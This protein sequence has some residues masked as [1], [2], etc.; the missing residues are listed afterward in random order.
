[1]V[2]VDKPVCYDSV[3]ACLC[4]DCQ[5]YD[6]VMSL[7][8][9][10]SSYW[11]SPLFRESSSVAESTSGLAVIDAVCAVGKRMRLHQSV[12]DPPVP[13]RRSPIFR[14]YLSRPDVAFADLSAPCFM[15][16]CDPVLPASCESDAVLSSCPATSAAASPV[17]ASPVS[18][19]PSS[20]ASVSSVAPSSGPVFAQPCRSF[21]CESDAVLSSCP[22]TS[23]AAS[24]VC[25][26]PV[27]PVPS[28]SASVSGVAPSSGPVFAQPYRSFAPVASCLRPPP[29]LSRPCP[30][31]SRLV[32]PPVQPFFLPCGSLLASPFRVPVVWFFR[33]AVPVLLS[34][35]FG[36]V[37]TCLLC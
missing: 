16:V 18:P 14:S 24:P 37:L 3:P 5:F 17:C 4:E 25:A 35:P 1:M 6:I 15:P 30:V 28:S 34:T 9:D 26:S 21:A 2:S 12:P 20:S 7:D 29:G 31:P 27:S 13:V 10:P 19:V 22:A 23:A 8:A 32:C 36:F 33:I 11:T